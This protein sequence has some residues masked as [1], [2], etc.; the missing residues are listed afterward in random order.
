MPQKS[1][2]ESPEIFMPVFEDASDERVCKFR[3]LLSVD[4]TMDVRRISRADYFKLWG[5]RYYS[6]ASPSCV[7]D[8]ELKTVIDERFYTESE[9]WTAKIRTRNS[10]RSS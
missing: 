4:E 2:A 7:Y 3:T 6:E 5:L 8:V 1:A 9:Y 10:S